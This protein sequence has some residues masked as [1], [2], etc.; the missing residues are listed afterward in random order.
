[1]KTSLKIAAVA[2]TAMILLVGCGNA[3]DRG[4]ESG[5]DKKDEKI[6]V[7]SNSV[8]DGRGDFLKEKAKEEGFNLEI[9]DLGGNDLLNRVI[10][11]KDAPIADVVFGMNQMM[12]SKV[13]DEGILDSYKPKWLD[14][15]DSSLVQED[16][17][18]SPLQEQ[19]VFM[20]YD[21]KKIKKDDAV[22]E[23]QQLGEE[24]SL[25][26]KYLVPKDLGGA[27]TNAIVYNILMNYQDKN[28]DMGISKKGWDE[29]KKYFK[30]GVPPTEG[31]SEIAEL[32]NG[33]VDYSFTW[34]SNVPIV[35][36][37]LGIELG[38]V[39]PSYG[40]PQ[41]VEQVGIIKK[42]KMKSNVKEFV[43][44]LGSAEVQ[45]EWAQKFGSA[46]VNEDAK[47]SI[48]PRITEILESTTPQDNDY[49]FINEHLDAWVEY[50]E[51]NI[52]G[53]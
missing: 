16:N 5:G 1:M 12:F 30:N 45:G 20:I 49:D 13:D 51:L 6:V 35:E 27:T 2:A 47:S 23:W 39:N 10:A 8:S 40:V 21:A 3:D 46:P 22:K 31:Q 14:K 43:D 52:L 4:S 34:L 25:K 15:V 50:I 41:T 11:E 17:K 48:N 44:F 19:R 33:V 32:A 9:V 42:D 7:Y 29:V 37:S 18:F 28:G 38:I 24:A 53:N 26:G 36:E